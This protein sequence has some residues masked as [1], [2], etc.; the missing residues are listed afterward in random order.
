[1]YHEYYILKNNTMI[2]LLVN[3]N[4]VVY[5]INSCLFLDYYKQLA[6]IKYQKFRTFLILSEIENVRN[7]LSEI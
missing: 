1:M 2:N 5:D 6:Y 7:F 3:C 4:I